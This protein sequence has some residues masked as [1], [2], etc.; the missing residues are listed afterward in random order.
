MSVRR[1]MLMSREGNSV[2][3]LVC[4]SPISEPDPGPS[5]DHA[6]RPSAWLSRDQFGEG[7]SEATHAGAHESTGE[8]VLGI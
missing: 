7:R 2:G 1:L 3:V 8:V 5:P 6:T 4:G